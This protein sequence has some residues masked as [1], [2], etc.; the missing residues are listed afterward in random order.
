MPIYRAARSPRSVRIRRP[1][2]RLASA[3]VSLASATLALP[4]HALNLMEAYQA[5]LEKD[6]A[7]QGAR[8][9]RAAANEYEA[10]GRAGLL[11]NV[12][13]SY[14][15]SKND[16]DRTIT[17]ANG[18]QTNDNPQYTS[19]A[20]TLQVRQP[21]FNMDAWQRY[22]G[23]KVQVNYSEAK[24]SGDTQ[25]L[26]NRLTTAY[27]AA[28]L[29]EDQLRLNVAQRD[30]YH[31]N[32]IANQNL[33]EK[34]AGT[35]TDVLEARARFEL[36][37]AQVLEAQDVVSNRRDELAVIVGGDPGALDTLAAILPE[38]P[39]A[40]ATLAE[41]EAL[42]TANNPAVR[43]QRY[44][45]DYAQT[46]VERNRAGHYPRVDLVASHSRNTSDSLFTFNQQSTINAI[47]VQMS[48][49]IYS[50]GGVN[51]QTRQAAA[52]LGAGQ[53]ELDAAL[54]KALVEVRKQ[55]QLVASSRIR[56]GAMEQA[57][58]SASEAVEATRKSV[59]GGQRVNLDVLTALQQLYTARRDLSEARHGYLLAYLRLHA[60]A[61]MLTDQDLG[62]I[63]GCFEARP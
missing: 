40:P 62:K 6:P 30:A 53:A 33:F 34:G 43:A 38:L 29:A 60:A 28:L 1:E 52:R 11:P 54:Q 23:G 48:L 36:A 12:S 3:L 14:N 42:A 27:L 46:E 59:A 50:G 58:R 17:A 16:A 24:F 21:L 26:I 41:W 39:M 63:A 19:K 37:Q 51:A 55:Y 45:V 32:Q 7:Y 9:N 13:A 8:H 20:A 2:L 49:P 47:G 56:M 25:D 15:F 44:S 5:A 61:G 4:A 31:E 22:M 18:N 10:I 57:V 35:R